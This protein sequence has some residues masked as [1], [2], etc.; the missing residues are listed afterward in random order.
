MEECRY[1]LDT[2]MSTIAEQ[3]DNPVVGL[4]RCELKDEYIKLHSV[5]SP[6]SIFESGVIK[7]QQGELDTLTVEEKAACAHLRTAKPGIN[8]IA[9]DINEEETLSMSNIINLRKPRRQESNSSY[10]NLEFI[11]GSYAEIERLFS[12][13]GGILASIREKM[14]SLMFVSLLFLKVK[15]GYWDLRTV[16]TVMSKSQSLNF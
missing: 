12:I 9:T 14:T 13:A 5:H 1:L 10:L 15:R 7:I 16:I 2:P 3:N 8:N 6:S 11:V 4:Y